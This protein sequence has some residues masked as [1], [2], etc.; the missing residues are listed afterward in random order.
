MPI[1][2]N[3]RLC[4]IYNW[5]STE[6]DTIEYQSKSKYAINLAFHYL[7]STF[8][9]WR[10]MTEIVANDN[11]TIYQEENFQTICKF[12]RIWLTDKWTFKNDLKKNHTYHSKIE[13]FLL[14]AIF[15]ALTISDA[16]SYVP[17][18]EHLMKIIGC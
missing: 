11:A 15:Q 3:D 10:D 17:S 14:F 5:G 1:V 9:E 18:W 13:W 12:V 16:K 7:T 2:R 8:T 6:S 4:W